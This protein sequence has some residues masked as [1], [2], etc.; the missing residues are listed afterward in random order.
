MLQEQTMLREQRG[1]TDRCCLMRVF[2]TY[3]FDRLLSTHTMTGRLIPVECAMH[4]CRRR[5]S[6]PHPLRDA[7]LS[8][9]RI[10]FRHSGL[11]LRSSQERSRARPYDTSF[12]PNIQYL[13][14]AM[15]QYPISRICLTTGSRPIR[16][17]HF[18]LGYSSRIRK[19][20]F[21]PTYLLPDSSTT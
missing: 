21:A 20:A 2:E 17:H 4:Q 5:D 15:S 11:A 7:I 18:H 13:L 14:R 12:R 19:N 9:A 6:N 1:V 3:K 10:P 16:A 8:L